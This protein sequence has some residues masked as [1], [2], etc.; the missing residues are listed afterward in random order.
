MIAISTSKEIIEM[1]IRNLLVKN[2]L[3]QSN[4]K[5]LLAGVETCEAS[6]Q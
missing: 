4:N 5:Q 2:V 3:S 6:L 1:D